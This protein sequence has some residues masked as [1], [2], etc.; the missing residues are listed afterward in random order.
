MLGAFRSVRMAPFVV[1][2][3]RASNQRTSPLKAVLWGWFAERWQSP[4]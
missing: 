2:D 1:Q 3:G 4:V